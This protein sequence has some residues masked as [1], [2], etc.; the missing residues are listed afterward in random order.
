MRGFEDIFFLIKKK[1]MILVAIL[2]VVNLWKTTYGQSK[3][4]VKWEKCILT[5]ILKI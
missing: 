3:Y 4:L 2:N 5:S 1:Q